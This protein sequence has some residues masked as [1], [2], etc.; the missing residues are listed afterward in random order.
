MGKMT[1]KNIMILADIGLLIAA[2]CWGG[3]FVAGDVAA[4]CFPTFWI[5]ALRYLGAAFVSLIV[6]SKAV[7]RSGWAEI[8][9]GLIL[10]GLLFVA[11]PFQ[12]IA[13]KYTTPSKQAFLIASYVAIVPFLSWLIL[14]QR[15]EKKAF[16]TGLLSLI[17]IGLISLNGALRME[18]GDILSLIFAVIYS[19]MIVMTGICARRAN[20][21]GVSFWQY[22]V[23]GVLALIVAFFLEEFPAV[24]PREGIGALLYL[25]IINTAVAFTL[26]NVAQ[27]HTSDTHAAVLVSTESVFGY[28]CGILLNGDPFTPK[29]LVGGLI[30]FGS[31]LLSVVH[32]EKKKAAA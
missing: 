16:L 2:L 21:L 15:P 5:M 1:Q 12:I 31:V 3:G 13:L 11:A 20:P 18:I 25:A 6:F 28:F 9:G 17:G 26:Q 8:K 7:R 27:R 29:V 30:V 10:G 32:F 4:E 14:K 24:F 22:L 19:F 23:T